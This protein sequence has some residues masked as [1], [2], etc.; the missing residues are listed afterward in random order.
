[1]TNSNYIEKIFNK[2]RDEI[3]LTDIEDYFASPQEETSIVEFK[4]GGVEIIDLYKEV[5]AFLNTEGG[6][7]I[8]GT[9]KEKKTN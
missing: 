2:S 3:S 9:P 8:V 6:L 4:S 5:T 7:I 1:M